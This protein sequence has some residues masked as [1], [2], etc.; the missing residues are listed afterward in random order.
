MFSFTGVREKVPLCSSRSS[1]VA[2]FS[3]LNAVDEEY[4]DKEGYNDKPFDTEDDIHL[5]IEGLD[6]I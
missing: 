2:E 6:R 3:F 5:L 4:D 1:S